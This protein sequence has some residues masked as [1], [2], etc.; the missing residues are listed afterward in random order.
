M[1]ENNKYPSQLAE[2]FQVRLP[3]GMRDKLRIAAEKNNRSMNSEIIDRL[4]ATFGF[5]ESKIFADMA[6]DYDKEMNDITQEVSDRLSKVHKEK[7]EE[8]RLATDRLEKLEESKR[9][10]EKNLRLIMSM[11]ELQYEVAL[12]KARGQEPPLLSGLN[13]PFEDG[14][15]GTFQKNEKGEYLADLAEAAEAE[16]ANGSVKLSRK[17]T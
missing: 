8:I 3:N 17:I 6:I 14:T 5:Q 15:P 13:A 10:N 7:L 1:E 16:A 2:R 11:M 12:A 4:Q 9:V